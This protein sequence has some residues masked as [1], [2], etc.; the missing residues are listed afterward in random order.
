MLWTE[1]FELRA[2]KLAWNK[3]LTILGVGFQNGS[4]TCIRVESEKHYGSHYEFGRM[5]KH[6]SAVLGMVINPLT[7]YMYSIAKDNCLISTDLGDYDGNFK[8]KAFKTKLTLMLDDR[9][10]YRFFLGDKDGNLYMLGYQT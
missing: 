1:S 9:I 7:G 6:T 8:E 5:R 4:V 2:T 10:N 3:E